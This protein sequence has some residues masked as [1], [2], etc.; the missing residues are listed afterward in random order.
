MARAGR[1][2]RLIMYQHML[3]RWSPAMIAIGLGMFALA[4]IEFTAPMGRFVTW[5]WQLAGGVGVLAMLIG[6]F[7]IVIKNFAYVQPTPNHLK[8]VTPFMRVNISYKRIKR[9][10]PSEM[11]AL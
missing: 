3:N 11:H 2:Y 4:Y 7:F 8:L 1:K 5:P 10:I 6:L 9:T